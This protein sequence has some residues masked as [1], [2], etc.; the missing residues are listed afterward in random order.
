MGQ[1]AVLAPGP[2]RRLSDPDWQGA[3]WADAVTKA[4]DET[5]MGGF[6]ENCPWGV[7]EIFDDGFMPS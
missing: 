6:P 1:E 5:G 4:I 2:E 3:I 7:E